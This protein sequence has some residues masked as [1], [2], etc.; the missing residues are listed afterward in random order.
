MRLQDGCSKCDSKV[1]FCLEADVGR[2]SGPVVLCVTW[3]PLGGTVRLVQGSACWRP[4]AGLNMLQS[5]LHKQHKGFSAGRV[6]K[7]HCVLK[8]GAEVR[9]GGSPGSRSDPGVIVV[10]V[11]SQ[12]RRRRS[13]S[14]STMTLRAGPQHPSGTGPL[15]FSTPSPAA[16]RLR[17]RVQDPARDETH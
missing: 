16:P 6:V 8:L 5:G 11:S 1:E 3:V 12:L 2:E 15:S 9:R 17:E 10:S 14:L 4:H 13:M 7:A